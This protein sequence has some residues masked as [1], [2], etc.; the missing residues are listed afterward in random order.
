MIQAVR[1]MLALASIVVRTQEV[2][3]DSLLFTWARTSLLVDWRQS[4]CRIEA[5]GGLPLLANR[6]ENIVPDVAD[7]LR[8]L[9]ADPNPDVR[10]RIAQ[11]LS[12]F[13]KFDE[14]FAWELAERFARKEQQVKV[15]FFFLNHSVQ[16][17]IAWRP[18]R[19]YELM[20]ILLERLERG[21]LASDETRFRE[22]TTDGLQGEMGRILAQAGLW[23]DHVP[24]R[25]CLTAC[26][27]DL[28]R[29]KPLL[30]SSIGSVI[31]VL[32]QTEPSREGELA[33]CRQR[34]I[35]WLSHLV[36]QTLTV[37]DDFEMRFR[38]G[39]LNNEEVHPSYQVA[40]E[41]A[42]EVATHVSF[43]LAWNR[44]NQDTNCVRADDTARQ[45]FLVEGHD[46]LA[47]LVRVHYAPAVRHVIELLRVLLPFNPCQVIEYA[48]QL[49][50]PDTDG[51]LRDYHVYDSLVWGEVRAF[52]RTILAE[53]PDTLRDL[54][55]GESLMRILDIFAKAGWPSALAIMN[56][57]ETVWR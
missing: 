14:S 16:R 20:A 6:E 39:E 3:L 23:H 53:H 25:E 36:Q 17:W 18:A 33:A 9:A 12:F 26:L 44:E 31:G 52:A 15:L 5:A 46:L 7:S 32:A 41:I 30:M 21:E 42:N 11:K 48:G 4:N 37:I 27:Q 8:R 24:A 54:S 2:T 38:L 35:V 57:L 13:V 34:V 28:P 55:T 40:V 56:E 51:R 19:C 10:L 45:R 50:S 29:L 22:E 43:R 1:L 49:L 47:K